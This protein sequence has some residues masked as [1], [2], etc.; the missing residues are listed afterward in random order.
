MLLENLKGVHSS[1]PGQSRVPSKGFLLKKNLNFLVTQERKWGTRGGHFGAA[2]ALVSLMLDF[3][4]YW[5]PLG[6]EEGVCMR[7]V[8]ISNLDILHYEEWTMALSV[9]NPSFC[10]S[11]PFHLVLVAV[12]RLYRLL[13]FYPNRALLIELLSGYMLFA[14]SLFHRSLFCLLGFVTI[15]LY[16]ESFSGLKC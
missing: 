9:F 14:T 3:P 1:E 4:G 2:W 12:S 7:L 10:C 6:K 16:H 15:L 5:S 13:E 11:S 8:W